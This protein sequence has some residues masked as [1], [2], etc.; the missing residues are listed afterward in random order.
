MEKG[1]FMRRLKNY[2]LPYLR[3]ILL[4]VV[5]KTVA[6]GMELLIPLFMERILD[7]SVPNG[8]LNHIFL[9]GGGMLIVAAGSLALNI[10]SNHMGAR[11]SGRIT[12]AL[13][14]DLFEKTM[15]LSA[16]QLDSLTVSSA[17][18]RLTSDTYYVNQFLARIQ[19]L[20]IR[21]PIL[22]VGGTAMM[23]LLDPVLALVLLALLPVISMA[24]FFISRT[25]AKLYS[26]Q[27][28]QLDQVVRII[29]E[30]ITG[31]R[32]IKA[33]GK[34]AYEKQRFYAVND[35]LCDLEQKSSMVSSISNPCAGL[36]M[37]TG[38][39]IV[40]LVG[41]YRV[42]AGAIVGGVIVAFLQY[43]TM[44]LTAMMGVTRIFIMW[45]KGEASA[46]RIADVLDVAPELPILHEDSN[47]ETD[48]HITFDQVSFSYTGNGNHIQDISFC[49]KKGQTLGI[50]GS[51][52][53]G[54][55]T[56]VQLLL[57][58][59]D[60][61]SGTIRIHG[62]DIRTLDPDTLR[63]NVGIVMQNDFL[64]E[65]TIRDNVRFFRNLPDE[66]VMQAL[67][68]AQADFVKDKNSLDVPVVFRGNNLSGGQKQR[69]LIARALAGNPDILILDDASSALDYR[70]DSN[71]RK[72]LHRNYPTATKI[73][74]TQRVSSLRHA[75]H[76]LML[77]DGRII[78]SGCHDFLM[79]SCPEYA[80][81][82]ETQMGALGEVL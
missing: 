76:I 45:A 15:L 53:S 17:Q 49:L 82:A 50:L 54:K 28:A 77:H 51:T 5:I 29:R 31:I 73:I 1:V 79:R 6:T 2:I 60:P 11:C 16:R 59:Y 25:G 36:I 63:N 58:F 72:A 20:G 13:R 39:V 26:Q 42:N 37:N 44:I 66:A 23:M 61:D 21:A 30:N 48:V 62:R 10:L 74:V 75:D 80:H 67:F 35:G 47:Q 78:G 4:T 34:E 56:I 7:V 81:L 46:K 19:R 55:T 68:D 32:V 71:L 12:E 52:G 38:L 8:N 41:A 64:M 33:L 70:T 3:Y 9:Y 57:R 69:L 27:Q 18:S 22:L 40:V 24:V 14:H 43:F 65:G